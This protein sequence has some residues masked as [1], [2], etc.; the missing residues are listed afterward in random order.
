VLSL[1]SAVLFPCLPISGQT[2]VEPHG[3]AADEHHAEPIK[4]DAEVPT[5]QHVGGIFHPK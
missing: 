5:C 2:A 1:F 4:F 3:L